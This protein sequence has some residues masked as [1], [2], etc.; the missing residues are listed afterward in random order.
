MANSDLQTFLEDRLRAIDPSVDLDPGSPAQVQFISP[1]LARLGTD[2]F[3]TDIDKFILDRF[4]QEFPDVYAGDPSVV[5]DTFVKPLIL[6]LEP[7]KRESLT[8][9][10]NQSLKDPTLLSDDEADALVANV[11]DERSS[12]GF[13]TVVARLFFANPSSI[14]VEIT[15]R[16]FTADGLNF[17]PSTPLFITAEEMVFNRSGSLFFMDVP[18]KAEAAGAEYNIEP[19]SLSGVNGVFGPV[20]VTNP[21][22]A[23]NGA[24]VI[25]TPSFMAQ[26]RESLNERSLVTRR[27]ASAR[28]RQVFQGEVRAVQIIGARDVE[29]ERDILV[30]DS[31]GHA[32][33]TGQ[34]SLYGNTALVQCRTVDDASTTTTP[35][36][37]DTLLVYLSKYEPLYASLDQSKRTLRLLVEEVIS[38]P[39][40]ESLGP[41][42][43][44]YL[45]RWSG[46]LPTGVTLP[47]VLVAEGGLA[48]KGTVHVSSLP[49]VG[50]VDLTVNN[51]EVHVYGHSD[52]YVRPVLQT[53]SKAVLTNLVDDPTGSD[54][55]IQ[56]TTLQTYGET[57]LVQNRVQDPSGGGF[58]FLANGVEEGDLLVIEAGD[59]AGSYVI[60]KVTS[61]PSYLFLRQ[62]LTKDATNLRYRITKKISINP[63]EPRIPKIPFGDIPNNDLQT[64]VGSNTFTVGADLLNFGVVEGDTLRI[65]SGFDKGD[66]TITGFNGGGQFPIVDRK[67][68]ASN[69]SLTYEVFTVLDNAEL[70]LVRVK[71]VLILDSA[72]QSTGITIPPAEPVAAVPLCDFSSAQVRGFSQRRSGFVLPALTEADGVTDDYVTG[73]RVAAVS[74]DRRFSFGFDPFDGIYRAMVFANGSQA[75]F[76][77][78]ADADKKCSYFLAVSEDTSK[79]V[80]YPPVDPKPGECLTIKN[81]P[82]KGSYLIQSVRKFKYDTSTGNDVWLYFIKIYGEFPVD[83]LRQLVSFLDDNGSPVTKITGATPSPIAFPSFFQG[84]YNGLGTQLSAVFGSLSIAGP[85]APELQSAID[86]LAQVDYE[87]GD[88]A[89]G[90]VRSYFKEPTLFQQ[91]TALHNNPTLFKFLST[92][93][94]SLFFRADP[95]RYAKH[96]I[97]P[98]RLRGDTVPVEYPRDL[99]PTVASTPVFT[100]TTR[101]TMFV[102]GVNED[103][104]L[105]VHPEIFFHG[106]LGI[107]PVGVDHQSAIQTVAG[108]TT[109]TAPSASGAIFT[110]DMVGNLL[111][112]EEGTDK[113]GYLV[114][115]FLNSSQLVVD[116]PM[117]ET[118]PSLLVSPGLT[119]QGSVSSFGFILVLTGPF[120][121]PL[122]NRIVS[123]VPVGFSNALINKY[124][125]LYGVDS[126]YQGSYKILGA[127]S[128]Q[129]LFVDRTPAMGDFPAFAPATD[130]RWFI[131]EAPV[132]AP[133]V[134]GFST[135][136]SGLR[137]IRIYDDI[138]EDFLITD[139]PTSTSASSLVVSGSVKPGVKQ[140]FRI[141]RANIRRV[142]P[143]EMSDNLDDSLFYFDTEV[144]SL[145]PSVASNIPEDSYGVVE[146]GTYE[147]FG[148]FHVVKD[149]TLTYSM[150]ETG[151]LEMPTK[152][153]PLES[154]DSPENFLSAV[155]APVQISYE[156]AD[157]VKQFQDFLDS[158]EDRVTVANM[159]ARHFLPSY[160]SYDASYVGGSAPSV[161]AKDI[162]TAIDNLAIETPIDV[163]E[164]QK[165][166]EQRGG[167]PETPTKVVVIIHDWDRKVWMEKSTNKVGLTDE[168]DPS[169]S[170][171]PFNGSPRVAYFVPGADVSGQTDIPYGERVKLTRL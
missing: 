83:V 158:P 42:Q 32:W 80:N 5:R 97:L 153:L 9:K 150:R 51:Q 140:P 107:T 170:A 92:S 154:A 102:A 12:G 96:E 71:E 167:N 148:Y 116:K 68:G 33:L 127:L 41:F 113:G 94:A 29:M 6:L 74:G 86:S 121:S 114:T 59:D 22:R 101:P 14:Q 123:P 89:R 87:W 115:Q 30:A 160:V 104:T 131:T 13:S 138:V 7:F 47:T 58:D 139:V 90:V 36:P 81:G 73:A 88:P 155:Q 65:S 146:K 62:N 117:T 91:H 44:A 79:A 3:E 34:V 75:E 84:I 10:R 130:G 141:Y 54:F 143:T 99:N 157:I 39:M 142:N 120:S 156:R 1:V 48:K 28:L 134:V 70:P 168:A 43:V 66:F 63:F 144:V 103:D 55:K 16:F 27:G 50:S 149:Y 124:I 57:A 145:D 67:A 108:S 122:Q 52:I 17:F 49:S 132:S 159:L 61:A 105:S 171:V 126:R 76:N 82:N 165:L 118:T 18:V 45:I 31:P 23:E 93:G 20:R 125:T 26:A 64:F 109:I 4:Q 147:S 100:D 151:T 40:Q 129:T 106:S 161:I 11:F 56:R 8:I 35:A 111:F 135:E 77:F 162:I 19:D 112:I 69:P 164:L 60:G 136:L 37:G 78:P 25:D 38:G 110:A 21:R 163:S 53:T 137:P 2:P 15:A 119:A 133:K 152:I 95:T 169:K 24:T 85:T 98:A 72:K 46:E 166:I 128:T